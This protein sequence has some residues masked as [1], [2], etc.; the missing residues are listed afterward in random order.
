MKRVSRADAKRALRPGAHRR[1]A[2]GLGRSERSNAQK[3][4]AWDSERFD[5]LRPSG[6]SILAAEV[7]TRA[8][9]A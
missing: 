4:I 6:R 2:D 5:W 7:A 3:L 8:R 1:D 9:A